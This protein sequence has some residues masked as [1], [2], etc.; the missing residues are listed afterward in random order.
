[1]M[2]TRAAAALGAD[3]TLHDL[4][5][6]AAFRMAR[7][8]QMLL[9]DVQWILGHRH[10]STTQTYLNPLPDE[11][12][13]NAVAFFTR[14]GQQSPPEAASGRQAAAGYNPESLKILFGDG[15]GA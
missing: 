3:H 2:F 5:H 7:D 13:A 4:R 12:I 6:T 9:T 10:L 8:P 15:G 1:M 14:R 11:V